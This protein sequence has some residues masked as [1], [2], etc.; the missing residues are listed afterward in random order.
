MW[1]SSCLAHGVA[2]VASIPCL[3]HW[4]TS[5]LLSSSSSLLLKQAMV[6]NYRL[7]V[8]PLTN[9]KIQSS[10]G[11]ERPPPGR[12]VRTRRRG[13]DYRSFADRLCTCPNPFP[14]ATAK[15]ATATKR[16][17]HN[18]APG[19]RPRHFAFVI[20]VRL[21]GRKKHDENGEMR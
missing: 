17:F 13:S 15:T 9:P 11:N 16:T 18:W 19:K 1:Q 10:I 12:S 2:I 7:P 20:V 14:A 21:A 6:R 5:R 8:A 3:I 4:Q